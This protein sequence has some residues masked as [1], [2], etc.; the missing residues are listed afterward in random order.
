MTDDPHA[1]AP[2]LRRGPARAKRALVLLHGR[3]AGA[4]DILR[5]GAALAPADT[6]FFAPEAAGRSWWP[7]SFL[8]PMAQLEPWLGSALAAADRAVAAA[9]AEGYADGDILLLGFSQG[10]CLALEY[11]ARAARPFMGV[12]ALS[13]GLVGTQDSESAPAADLYGHAPKCFDYAARLDGLPT[14]LG[15]HAQ[16]PHIPL[17]RVRESETVLQKLGAHCAVTIHPGA[18]HGVVQGD[19]NAAR[20]MLETRKI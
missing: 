7:T 12:C 17:R 8:A 1:G 2:M 3:G 5:L 9:H 14:Y 18:G 13:G 6:A 15:C 10:A 20:T 19:V 4:E 16:D 11:A